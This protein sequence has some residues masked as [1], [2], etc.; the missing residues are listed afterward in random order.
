LDAV[1]AFRPVNYTY[2]GL[3]DTP[4]GMKGVGFI[5]QEAQEVAPYMI[6]TVN[7]KLHPED[8]ETTDVYYLDPSA[9]PFINLNAIKELDMTIS[10]FRADVDERVTENTQEIKDLK[11]EVERLK[12]E[13]EV[14]K[15][16]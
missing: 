2:N 8:A 9:L 15:S 1:R 13:V 10:G 16:R 14:L 4:E 6:K 3:A 12:A 11:A 7:Q 5:A